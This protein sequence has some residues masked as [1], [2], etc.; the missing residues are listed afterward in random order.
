MAGCNDSCNCLLEGGDGIETDGLG[1]PEAPY[2]IGTED[3]R[4]I[5]YA[6]TAAERTALSVT[7]DDIGLIAY[8]TDTGIAWAYDGAAEGW[9]RLSVYTVAT[10]NAS[11][12]LS[13]PTTD[14]Q[15]IVSLD[16]GVGVWE[17]HAKGYIEAMLTAG[18]GWDVSLWDDTADADLDQTSMA[19][20]G[21]ELGAV[22]ASYWRPWACQDLLTLTVPSTIALRIRRA[23]TGGTQLAQRTKLMASGVPGLR[24]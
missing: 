3:G 11:T 18:T 9:R 2:V 6:L 1:S 7:D 21:G 15:L 24:P 8:E 14:K 13:A 12:T 22:S 23:T 16:L 5:P 4:L 20:S 17:L 19:V 10:E